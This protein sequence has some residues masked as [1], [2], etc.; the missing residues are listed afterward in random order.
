M[1]RFR[2]PSGRRCRDGRVGDW[3]EPGSTRTG[4]RLGVGN[5]PLGVVEILVKPVVEDVPRA[6]GVID[7]AGR[8]FGRA[9]DLVVAL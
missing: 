6:G 3:A 2:F 5:V 8:G 9:R 7:G 4:L 1:P